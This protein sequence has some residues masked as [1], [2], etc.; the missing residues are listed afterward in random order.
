MPDEKTEG[1]IGTDPAADRKLILQAKKMDL[2][3]GWIG[4]VIGSPK[5]APN[6][7]A[8]LSIL[9]GFASGVGLSLTYPSQW[10]EFWKLILP[11]LTLALGYVFGQK[12]S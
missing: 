3:A 1:R 7:L 6:N 11:I 9:L 5:N 12:G 8:F 2:E 4:R 10:L